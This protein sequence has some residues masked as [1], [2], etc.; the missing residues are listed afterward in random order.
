MLCELELDGVAAPAPLVDD[1]DDDTLVRLSVDESGGGWVFNGLPSNRL[2]APV[3]GLNF[4]SGS[5]GGS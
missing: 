4:G 3:N 5:A 1:E 2:A